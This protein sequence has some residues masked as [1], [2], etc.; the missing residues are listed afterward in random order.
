MINN[1]LFMFLCRNFSNILWKIFVHVLKLIL[2]LHRQ[3]FDNVKSKFKPMENTKLTYS[4]FKR[5]EKLE[6]EADRLMRFAK[7]NGDRIEISHWSSYSH[8][9]IGTSVYDGYVINAAKKEAERQYY[10]IQEQINL[11]KDLSREEDEIQINNIQLNNN[12]FISVSPQ[13]IEGSAPSF[14]RRIITL[15]KEKRNAAA[16]DALKSS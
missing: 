15:W 16:S 9:R 2:P 10:L 14:I 11:I 1:Q 7:E 12:V 8:G 3:I 4:N 13:D 5:I 6:L